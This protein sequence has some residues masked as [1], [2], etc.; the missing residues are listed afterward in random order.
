MRRRKLKYVTALQ[1]KVARLES[2]RE[3]LQ[4]QIAGDYTR[5]WQSYDKALNEM[6]EMDEGDDT[7]RLLRNLEWLRF[8]EI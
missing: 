8:Y 5:A 6:D 1:E 2:T 3:A 4:A 7:C